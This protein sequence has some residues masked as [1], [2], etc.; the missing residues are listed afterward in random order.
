VGW[1]GRVKLW[2][3]NFQIR[4]SYKHYDEN[5]NSVSIS[6]NGKYLAT[7][8]AGKTV[9][10][11]DVTSMSDFTREFESESLIHQLTFNP[12]KQWIAAATH[13]GVKIW[14]LMSNSKSPMA[15]LRV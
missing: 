3:T 14:D 9:R 10:I 4:C 13:D 6:P 15:N 1:D 11:Y 12:K 7:G 2:N 5:V 8:G